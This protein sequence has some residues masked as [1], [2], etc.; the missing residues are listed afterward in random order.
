MLSVIE[1]DYADLFFY[2]YT[3]SFYIY[4]KLLDPADH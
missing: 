4:Y 3:H 2:L 1:T